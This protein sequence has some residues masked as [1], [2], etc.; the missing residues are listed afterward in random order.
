M[1]LPEEGF[2]VRQMLQHVAEIDRRHRVIR[3]GPGLCQVK[4]VVNVRP[5][6]EIAIQQARLLTAFPRAQVQVKPVGGH[7]TNRW[8]RQCIRLQQSLYPPLRA[9]RNRQSS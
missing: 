8:F 6:V 5:W 3:K 7:R 2:R 9:V 4:D 1:R